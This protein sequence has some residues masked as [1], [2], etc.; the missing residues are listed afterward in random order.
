[1]ENV[2]HH[3]EEEEEGKMFP[4]IRE[5]LSQQELDELGSELEAA[6]GKKERKAG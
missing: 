6:K 4:K 2:D 3:A 5:I 1:M